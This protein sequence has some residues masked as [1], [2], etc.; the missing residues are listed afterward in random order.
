M[1]SQYAFDY[2]KDKFKNIKKL[3][4]YQS[5]MVLTK[6]KEKVKKKMKYAILTKVTNL[7]MK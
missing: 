3:Y 4:D 6:C 1:Q 5:D 7:S 2:F